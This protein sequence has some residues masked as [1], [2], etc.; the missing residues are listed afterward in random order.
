MQEGAD[1]G[2]EGIAWQL[3]WH[4]AGCEG[5]A[6]GLSALSQKMGWQGSRC[7]GMELTLLTHCSQDH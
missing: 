3:G 5:D 1:E 6:P 7:L 4:V 2:Q